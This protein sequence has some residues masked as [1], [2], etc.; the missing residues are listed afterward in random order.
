MIIRPLSSG[1]RS[2]GNQSTRAFKP[3]VNDAAKKMMPVIL[4]TLGESALIRCIRCR[5]EHPGISAVPCHAL[6]L[7]IGHVLGHRR[8]AKAGAMVTN[9]ARLH[10]HASRGRAEGQGERGAPASPESRPAR[11]ARAAAESVADMSGP[12][13]RPHDLADKALR[14]RGAT[15][16]VA[17]AARANTNIIVVLAHVGL[18][19]SLGWP[20]A[21]VALISLTIWNAAMA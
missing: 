7:Q 8:R 16:A 17:N 5:I 4:A 11:A 20:T 9:H 13:G 19:A 12:L 18:T 6:S 10:H 14:T 15:S 21:L 2:L 1:I 3:A